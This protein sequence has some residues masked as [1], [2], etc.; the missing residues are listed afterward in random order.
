MRAHS[1][2]KPLFKYLVHP[3]WRLQR[4]QTLGVRGLVRDR[5]DK[6][7]LLRHTYAPGW[8]FPGGG[9]ERDE[10]LEDALTRE[11]REE[12][13]V[14]TLKP[15]KLFGIYAN[16]EHFRSDHVALFVIDHWDQRPRKT[17]EIAEYNF[18]NL[19]KVPDG[20]TQGTNRRLDEVFRSRPVGPHW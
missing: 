19:D 15:P 16:F 8:H 11:L 7:L 9:V 17:M 5:D 18:F 14:E 12:V 3:F 10:T 1:V 2:L 13:G 6:V 4:G 20:V